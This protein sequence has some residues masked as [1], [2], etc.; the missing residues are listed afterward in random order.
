MMNHPK[1]IKIYSK[2][3]DVTGVINITEPGSVGEDELAYI[4][5][6]WGSGDVI[7]DIVTEDNLHNAIADGV[8]AIVE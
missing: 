6:G 2:T 5:E 4:I 7:T 8:A 1:T 3:W